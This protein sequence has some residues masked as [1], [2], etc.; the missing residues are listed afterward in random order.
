MSEERAYYLDNDKKIQIVVN[1]YYDEYMIDLYTNETHRGIPFTYSKK[2][3]KG[4]ADF[5]YSIIEE[6]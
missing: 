5:L 4:L 1:S 3:I 2:Q 6:K